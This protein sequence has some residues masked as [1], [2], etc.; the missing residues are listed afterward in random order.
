MLMNFFSSND[1]TSSLEEIQYSPS[2]SSLVSS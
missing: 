1:D 2:P